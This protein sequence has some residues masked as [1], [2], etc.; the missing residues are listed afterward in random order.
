MYC[1]QGHVMVPICEFDLSVA[2]KESRPE[3]GWFIRDYTVV[4][5]SLQT[6]KHPTC[7][8][9]YGDFVLIHDSKP[10]EEKKY[11]LFK[12]LRCGEERKTPESSYR[13]TREA[14][15]PKCGTEFLGGVT[16]CQGEHSPFPRVPTCSFKDTTGRLDDPWLGGLEAC[17]EVGSL[18]T[19]EEWQELK[20]MKAQ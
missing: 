14:K 1:K 2:W 17:E 3:G 13:S 4:P 19:P 15:C 16:K 11:T 5:Q 8:T 20:R 10:E 7:R 6:P 12:C 9:K 18:F